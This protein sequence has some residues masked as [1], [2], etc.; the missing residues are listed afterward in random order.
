MPVL[1]TGFFVESFWV[2]RDADVARVVDF[3]VVDFFDDDFVDF[4][5]LV[6]LADD[7]ALLSPVCARSAGELSANM[8]SVR[9]IAISDIDA[10]A[11]LRPRLRA[12]RMT[13]R[14]VTLCG[15]NVWRRRM[16]R[17]RMERCRRLTRRGSGITHPKIAC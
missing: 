1:R 14:E 5:L 4:T 11:L 17:S 15:K 2:C 12:R 9:A 16:E 10:R 7:L 13:K 8:P 6:V 3:F